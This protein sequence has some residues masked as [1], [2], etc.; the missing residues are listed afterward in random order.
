[1]K[2]NLLTRQGLNP[3]PPDYQ[4]DAHPTEPPRPAYCNIYCECPKISPTLFYTFLAKNLL[5][6]QL[7]LKIL[8]GMANSLD[9]DKTAPAV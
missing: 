6:M 8:I 7:F 4:S 5:F 2:E 1:M 9:P 3:Q